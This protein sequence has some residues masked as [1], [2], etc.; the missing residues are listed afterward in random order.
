MRV[1]TPIYERVAVMLLISMQSL[2]LDNSCLLMHSY[3]LSDKNVH[4]WTKQHI[5]L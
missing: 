5:H 4:T 2:Q 3:V 1:D